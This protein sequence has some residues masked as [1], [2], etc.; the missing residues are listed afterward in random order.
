MGRDLS[1]QM[2]LSLFEAN[3]G[4]FETC[5]HSTGWANQQPGPENPTIHSVTFLRKQGRPIEEMHTM[6]SRV[7]F[8]NDAQYVVN[9]D[10]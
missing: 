10:E 3:I 2:A 4:N 1:S 6:Q 5:L 8:A 9:N 7:R